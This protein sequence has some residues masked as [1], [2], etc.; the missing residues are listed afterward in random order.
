MN[1]SECCVCVMA[2]SAA[3]QKRMMVPYCCGSVSTNKLHCV[4][5]FL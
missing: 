2:F 4:W 3:R 5:F 1:L